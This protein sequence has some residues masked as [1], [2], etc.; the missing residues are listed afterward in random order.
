VKVPKWVLVH[1][2]AG[3]GSWVLTSAGQKSFDPKRAELKKKKS[4]KIE[5]K[6]FI[7]LWFPMCSH[8]VPF[9]F[10][11]G[12]HQVLNM[13]PKFPMCSPTCSP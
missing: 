5:R 13:F 12:S 7:S 10:P 1:P 8:Y 9:K 6:K 4:L 3:V 2:G 11:K